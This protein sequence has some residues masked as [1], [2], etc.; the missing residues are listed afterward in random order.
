MSTR[1][2][3]VVA[4]VCVFGLLLWGI[5]WPLFTIFLNLKT[6]TEAQESLLTSLRQKYPDHAFAKGGVGFQGPSVGIRISSRP[7]PQVKKEMLGFV[8]DEIEIRKCR[9][10]IILDFMIENQRLLLYKSSKMGEWI[11]ER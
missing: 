2:R 3:I 8:A 10:D 4:T 1:A 9:V 7:N 6:G 5:G 11:E